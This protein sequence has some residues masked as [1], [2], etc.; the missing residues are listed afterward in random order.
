MVEDNPLRTVFKNEDSGPAR[1]YK[2][3]ITMK[4]ITDWLSAL[5]TAGGR[6]RPCYIEVDVEMQGDGAE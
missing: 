1:Y 2:T 6:G 5:R 4:D 3:D